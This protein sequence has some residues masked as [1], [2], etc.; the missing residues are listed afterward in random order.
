MFLR[1]KAIP[2]VI[3]ISAFLTASLVSLA[4]EP[5]DLSPEQSARPRTEKDPSLIASIPARFNFVEDGAF[6]VG[7]APGGTPPIATYATD[8]ATVVGADPDIAQLIADKLGRKLNLAA[9]AWEDWP[10]GLASGK[11]DAVISNVGVTEERKL[12]FDFSSYRQGLHGFYVKVDSPITSIKEPKD[13]AGLR[14]ITDAGTIQEKIMVEWNRLNVEA[15]LK[16]AEIIYLDD[17]AA[18][19]LA[20]RSGRADA[21]FSMNS[22]QAYQAALTGETRSVGTVNAGWP[23]TT[24]VGV[25]TKKDSGIADAITAALNETIKEGTY[26]KALARWSLSSEQIAQSRTNPPGLKKY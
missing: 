10:L 25:V 20:I 9:V 7:I 4:S 2:A 3:G 11:Y 13:I 24:D 12:K 8:A 17:T 16:P 18:S 14:I 5:F 1:T 26:A 6:T 19:S 23:L 15:G 22:V 21:I